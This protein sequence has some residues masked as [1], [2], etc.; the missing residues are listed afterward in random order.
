MADSVGGRGHWMQTSL[1]GQFFPGDPR[2]EEIFISDI[3]NGLALDCRYA[4]QGRIDRFYSVAEHSYHIAS[5]ILH[6]RPGEYALALAGLLH[7]G[8]ESYLNDLAHAV[9]RELTGAKYKAGAS[10][11]QR[12]ILEKYGVL[13]V[14]EAEHNYIKSLDCRIVPMEKAVVH[15]PG[16]VWD[17]DSLPPL[18]GVVIQCWDPMTAKRAFLDMYAY[19]CSKLNMEKE[20]YE[21]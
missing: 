13:D 3:A 19:L 2:P 5:F 12:M 8:E 15:K 20:D 17:Y 21:I 11:I 4:G 16:W 7:D 6:D 10:K 14:F 18:D 9:K 1:G